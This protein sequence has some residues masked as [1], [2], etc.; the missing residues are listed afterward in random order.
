MC[1]ECSAQWFYGSH[2]AAIY[3]IV[4]YFYIHGFSHRS[5]SHNFHQMKLHWCKH[6]SLTKWIMI[7]NV[8][9]ILEMGIV[10]HQ[11]KSISSCVKN[12]FTNGSKRLW[13]VQFVQWLYIYAQNQTLLLFH[14][15]CIWNDSVF[16]I[17]NSV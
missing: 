9:F 5:K 15:L 16:A 4:H 3:N 10:F 6:W 7:K 13:F 14:I 12:S 1:C 8:H 17:K 2:Q 11:F